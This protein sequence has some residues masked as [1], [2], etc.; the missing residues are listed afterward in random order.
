MCVR[1]CVCEWNGKKHHRF[2]V[3]EEEGGEVV[4]EGRTTNDWKDGGNGRDVAVSLF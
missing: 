2:R 4:D 3:C 1:V